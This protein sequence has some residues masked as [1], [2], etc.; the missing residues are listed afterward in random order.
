M[1]E[2]VTVDAKALRSIN[3]LKKALRNLP[4]TATARIAARAAPAMSTLAQDAHASGKTVYDRPRPLG[5]DGDE[6]SLERTGATRRALNFIATGRDIRTAALPRYAKYLIGKYDL[7]PNGPLPA[8]W[9]ERLQE[10]AARVL[11]DEI[12]RGGGA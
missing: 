4:I 8:S 9:R 1:G 7:L 2:V 10:I 12:Q 5:V 3:S 11:Y 6:I